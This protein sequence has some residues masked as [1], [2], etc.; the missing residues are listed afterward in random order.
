MSNDVL[1]DILFEDRPHALAPIVAAWLTSSRRFAR[2]ARDHQTK[3]R[4]KLRAA[5]DPESVRDLHLELETAFQFTL[6]KALTPVYEPSTSTSRGPDFAV[7]YTTS[8]EFMVEVTRVRPDSDAPT[9]AASDR[10]GPDDDLARTARAALSE[11]RLA[12]VLASKLG[13]AVAGHANLLI[14]AIDAPPPLKE[15]I[16]VAMRGIRR[17]VETSDLAVLQRQGFADRGTYLRRADRLSAILIRRAPDPH[18]G[19]ERIPASPVTLWSNPHA[20]IPL[21]NKVQ[22]TVLGVVGPRTAVD[23]ATFAS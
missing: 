11:R 2:F 21:P 3:I 20:A 12:G 4:K 7:H 8:L 5:Q 13:Q 16:D 15:D 14:V 18:Q 10:A 9:I 23:P 19:A 1:L 22:S 6:A 17:R